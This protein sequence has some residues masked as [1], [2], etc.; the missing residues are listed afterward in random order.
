MPVDLGLNNLMR[1]GACTGGCGDAV[2]FR[3]SGH[4]IGNCGS[5]GET[6]GN[7]GFPPG[8]FP[9]LQSFDEAWVGFDA[10]P[11]TFEEIVS[12]IVRHAFVPDQVGND[13]GGAARYTLSWFQNQIYVERERAAKGCDYL[14]AVDEDA[15]SVSEDFVNVVA[16]CFQV[17]T[18]IC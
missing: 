15:L 1:T 4:G 18:K 14:L 16:D 9:V 10:C 7:S 5:G 13:H 12:V 2:C 11:L 17:G 3:V 8:A 6:S